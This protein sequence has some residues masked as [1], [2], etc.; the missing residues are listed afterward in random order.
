MHQTSF[1]HAHPP[2]DSIPPANLLTDRTFIRSASSHPPP[3]SRPRDTTQPP[4]ATPSPGEPPSHPPPRPRPGNHPAAH[5]QSLHH[6][7]RPTSP[8][9]GPRPRDTTQ[10]PTAR[11]S[12][13]GGQP[14]PTARASTTRPTSSPPPPVPRPRRTPSRPPPGPPPWESPSRPNLSTQFCTLSGFCRTPS[15]DSVAFSMAIRTGSK[16][17]RA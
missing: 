8:P 15:M 4:T 2:S 3:G 7:A 12:T 10:S 6:A 9:P 16:L 13:L 5:R 11:V 17:N 14:L 1:R